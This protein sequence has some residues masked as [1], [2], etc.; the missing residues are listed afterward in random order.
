MAE[1]DY[2]YWFNLG[3]WTIKEAALLLTGHDPELMPNPR[4][5]KDVPSNLLEASKLRRVFLRRTEIRDYG[6]TD[7]FWFIL[8]AEGF[9]E[10]SEPIQTQYEKILINLYGQSVSSNG[11][12]RLFFANEGLK[13]YDQAKRL[14][15]NSGQNLK[16]YSENR[17]KHNKEKERENLLKLL[18][19]LSRMLIEE[20][21]RRVQLNGRLN[22]DKYVSEILQY[23]DESGIDNEGLGK[24]TLK[25]KL[26]LAENTVKDYQFDS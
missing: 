21:G 15:E 17:G 23:I 14:F 2:T 1:L 3:R 13:F 7:Y 25:S 4:L 19:V 11:A 8:A 6:A 10:F 5:A 20:K 9:V 12:T 26:T 22:M 24:N 18:G 16:S